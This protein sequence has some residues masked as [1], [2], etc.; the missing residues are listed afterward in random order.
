SH[1]DMAVE[2]AGKETN[3]RRKESL[4]KELQH[5][6]HALDKRRAELDKAK[7]ELDAANLK[8]KEE[9]TDKLAEAKKKMEDAEDNLKRQT[10]AFDRFA[11]TAVQKQWGAG[12][13]F[14]ALPIID[15][16][17]SPT[18]PN[19][20][21]LNDLTIDYSFKQVPRYDRCTTCHLGIDRP[22]FDRKK[23]EALT[24]PAGA[25]EDSLKKAR[26]LLIARQKKGES[27]GFDPHDLPTKAEPVKMTKG[28]ITQ[29]A[30]HPRLDLFVDSNSPHGMEKFGCTICHAG[31]GSS[32]SFTLASHT[33]ADAR[34][35]AEW[36]KNHDWERIHDWDYPMHSSRFVE[37][38]CLQCHHQ[39][40]DLIRNGT[41]E[42][43]PKLL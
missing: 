30:T 16:M 28:E 22:M 3:P 7:S 24:K 27:L 14:R 10:A 13:Y 5:R 33:P 19:Q 1:Y 37:A 35:T 4:E 8:L 15:Y 32:T 23:L 40:T 42:E 9:V 21:V 39:V 11:K 41:K 36:K 43:A 38:S 26:A 2:D 17:A 6:R 34:Q 12:N 18:K 31:Q 29:Y 20:I 25:L